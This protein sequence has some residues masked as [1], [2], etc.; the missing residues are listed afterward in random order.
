MSNAGL[1]CVTKASLNANQLR[2]RIMC[3]KAGTRMQG[4]K[5]N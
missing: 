1:G 4:K 2:P 3:A 5:H